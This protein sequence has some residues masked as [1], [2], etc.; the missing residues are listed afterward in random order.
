VEVLEQESNTK[1][2]SVQTHEIATQRL[3]CQKWMVSVW[4]A[5]LFH[6]PD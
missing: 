4:I 2:A 6:L 3:V 5:N 1:M